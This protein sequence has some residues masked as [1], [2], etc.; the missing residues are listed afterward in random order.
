MDRE[1]TNET[2]PANGHFVR[3]TVRDSVFGDLFRDKKY[4]LQLYQVLHPEDDTV[5]EDDFTDITIRNVLVNDLYNDL[6]CIVRGKLIILCECQSRWTL[7]IIIRALLYMARSYQL[8]FKEQ[9]VDL[10]SK[11]K[12]FIPRPELYVI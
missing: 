11:K 5:T 1:K 10:Y 12:V 8:Y 7:N 2:H 6:G 3:L 9:G 4:L